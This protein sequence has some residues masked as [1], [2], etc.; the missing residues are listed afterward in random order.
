MLGGPIG[1]MLQTLLNKDII[2]PELL[3]Q[4]SDEYHLILEYGVGEEWG[5][6]VSTCANRVYHFTWWS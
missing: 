1:P 6:H 4:D 5:G 3:K 2:I